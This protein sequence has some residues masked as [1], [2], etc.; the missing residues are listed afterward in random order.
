M[1]V[2]INEIMGVGGER[3]NVWVKTKERK[4]DTKKQRNLGEHNS[5]K[6]KVKGVGRMIQI[7]KTAKRHKNIFCGVF[8]FSLSLFG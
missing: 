3:L 2:T 6:T 7:W 1:D 5:K 8:L 4:R